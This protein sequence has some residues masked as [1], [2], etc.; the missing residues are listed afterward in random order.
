MGVPC[1]PRNRRGFDRAALE[2]TTRTFAAS[3]NLEVKRYQ[4]AGNP[5]DVDRF[6]DKKVKWSQTLKRILVFGRLLKWDAKHLL[7]GSYRPFTR[8]WVYADDV[9]V[10]RLGKLRC[11][12]SSSTKNVS[13]TVTERASQPPFACLA[14]DG[15]PEL[16]LCATTDGCQTVGLTCTDDAGATR[17]NVT[18]WALAQ[19]HAHYKTK[20]ITKEA[21]FQYVYAVLHHSEY[22]SRYA[23]DLKRELP[24][25]PFVP[26]FWPFAKAGEKLAKLHIDYE[27]QPE[28]PIKR[29]EDKDEALDFRVEK[30]KLS[31]DKTEIIYNDFLTLAGVPPEAFEYRLGNRSA[32]EWIIDQYQVSKDARSGIVNDPNRP[33]DPEYIIRLIGQVIHVSLE[34]MKIVKA[35]PPLAPA[36]P[37]KSTRAVAN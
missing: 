36:A 22:R 26:D 23:E 35:L 12:F 34:T 30:M 19:F 11:F 7:Q 24:R 21:I 37:K 32:L 6:V 8:E 13:I 15:P 31:R 17:D 14:V 29:V 20:R 1:S 2:E 33:D 3:Y 27:V 10:D 9:V 18:D 5:R 28:Y 4:A 16:H 25:I